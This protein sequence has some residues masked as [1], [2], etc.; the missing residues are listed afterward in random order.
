[1]TMMS[2]ATQLTGIVEQAP[3]GTVTLPGSLQERVIY[4]KYESQNPM[5]SD[6]QHGPEWNEQFVV[7]TRLGITEDHG[8]IMDFLGTPR[9]E[10]G[11]TNQGEVLEGDTLIL[12]EEAS[13][14]PVPRYVAYEFRLAKIEK[15]D[16]PARREKLQ[17]THEQQRNESE[18]N[19]MNSLNRFF[20]QFQANGQTMK[21]PESPEGLTQLLAGLAPEQRSAMLQLAED[22]AND[23]KEEAAERKGK[24][25]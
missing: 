18:S 2:F 15:T 4:T 1:M 19:L 20:T 12:R 7:S 6:T 9:G 10:I 25:K 17:M 22:E 3:L 14:K 13:G 8:V 23:R 11:I 16:G 5:V 21:A 24:G